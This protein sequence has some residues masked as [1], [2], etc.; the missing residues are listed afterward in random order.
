[1]SDAVLSNV[2]PEVPWIIGAGTTWNP[3]PFVWK[4]ENGV[5]INL[6][7]YSAR[8]KIRASHDASAVLLDASAYVTL[9]GAAGTITVNIPDTIIAAQTWTQGVY[10]LE[11]ESGPGATTQLL[12]GE[13]SLVPGKSG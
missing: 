13:I 8:L 10:V 11:V 2:A 7:G 4:D 3:D 5:A 12:R 1:M 6:T 9:G